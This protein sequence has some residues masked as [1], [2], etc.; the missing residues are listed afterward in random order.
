[1][2]AKK[3]IEIVKRINSLEEYEQKTSADYGKVVGKY[4]EHPLINLVLF[5]EQLLT[6]TSI[7]VAHARSLSQTSEVFTSKL[8]RQ[9]KD[10]S[11]WP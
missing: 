7:G 9:P 2:G 1:M 5:F 3:Q 11:L 10:L 8:K 4:Q 6:I